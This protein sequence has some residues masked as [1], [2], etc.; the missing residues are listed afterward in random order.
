MSSLTPDQEMSDSLEFSAPSNTQQT[1]DNYAVTTDPTSD[2]SLEAQALDGLEGPSDSDSVASST[3][4]LE[5]SMTGVVTEE[6]ELQQPTYPAHDNDNPDISL[7]SLMPTSRELYSQQL[8]YLPTTD[9]M[10]WH[11]QGFKGLVD[12]QFRLFREDNVGILRDSVRSYLSIPF[13]WKHH[14]SAAFNVHLNVLLDPE[15]SFDPHGGLVFSMRVP[16]PQE[17]LHLTPSERYEWWIKRQ[18]FQHDS[19]VCL[20]NKDKDMMFAAVGHYKDHNLLKN[21]YGSD[22]VRIFFRPFEQSNRFIDWLLANAD[23]RV[24]RNYT[25]LEFPDLKSWSFVP[26]LR[27]LQQMSNMPDTALST[28][29]EPS[30]LTRPIWIRPAHYA[31]GDNFKFRLGKAVAGDGQHELAVSDLFDSTAMPAGSSLDN[32]QTSAYLHAL[33]HRVALIQGPPGTGKSYTAVAIIETLL[34]NL[35]SDVTGPIL[36]VS[37]TN[38]ALDGLL[39]KLQAAGVSNMIRVGSQSKSD[40]LEDINL[41]VLMKYQPQL[42]EDK[43][44][45]KKAGDKFFGRGR[46]IRSSLAK[47][48]KV[49]DDAERMRICSDI[50]L[51]LERWT[52]AQEEYSAIMARHPLNVLKRASVIGVTAG[53]IAVRRELFEKLD[54]KVI[55]FEEAG[56]IPEALAL[57]SITPSM[58][59]CILIG[60]HKQLLPKV[61]RKELERSTNAQFGFD[62]SLLERLIDFGLPFEVLNMQYRMHPEIS[63]LSRCTLYPMLEDAAAVQHLPA[64][65]SL[66]E[67]IFWFDHQQHETKLGKAIKVNTLEAEMITGLVRHLVSQDDVQGGNILV[68]TPYVAQA[69]ALQKKIEEFHPVEVVFGKDSRDQEQPVDV[70]L[71][72][73]RIATV[74]SIQGDESEIVLLSMVRSN[75]WEST[76]FIKSENRAIVALSRAK[77]AM[78]IFGNMTMLQKVPFWSQVLSALDEANKIGTAL[79]V[80]CP[81]HPGHTIQIKEPA[82]FGRYSPNGGCEVPCGKP[83]ACNHRCPELCHGDLLHGRTVCL[84]PCREVLDCGHTCANVCGVACTERCEV[85]IDNPSVVLPCGHKAPSGIPC[86]KYQDPVLLQDACSESVEVQLDCGHKIQR[87]CPEDDVPACASDC[88]KPLPCGHNCV[89]QCHVGHDCPPCQSP[90]A[91][92]CQHQTCRETCSEICIPCLHPDCAASLHAGTRQFVMN[93]RTMYARLANDAL[94]EIRK[95]QAT[96][97]AASG[98]LSKRL[99]KKP[100]TITSDAGGKRTHITAINRLAGGTRYKATLGLLSSLSTLFQRAAAAE[101]ALQHAWDSHPHHPR[102]QLQERILLLLLSARLEVAAVADFLAL[103]A[104]SGAA[105]QPLTLDFAACRA[106]CEKVAEA[107]RARGLPGVAAEADVV[108]AQ[109]GVLE[110]RAPVGHPEALRGEAV[111]RLG[112]AEGALAALAEEGFGARWCEGIR[113]E[114]RNARRALAGEEGRWG[115]DVGVRADGFAARVEAGVREVRGAVVWRVCGRGHYF[116]VGVAEGGGVCSGCGGPAWVRAIAEGEEDV[117]MEGPLES[118]GKSIPFGPLLGATEL[119]H[120]LKFSLDNVLRALLVPTRPSIAFLRPCVAWEIDDTMKICVRAINTSLHARQLACSSHKSSNTMGCYG[121]THGYSRLVLVESTQW[122]RLFKDYGESAWCGSARRF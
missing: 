106:R 77:R 12:R 96:A 67:R 1:G 110:R 104:R 64:V 121:T 9:P 42:P 81:R 18:G 49:N 21:D 105:A 112:G 65:A 74:D 60:D 54:C 122:R 62:K 88:G 109:W 5:E 58:E 85:Q 79:E 15:L 100:A 94:Q 76:G 118:T 68:I 34:Q 33:R 16:Q 75:D 111:G 24:R 70:G 28:A 72:R 89:V 91:L 25:L 95:L 41:D 31:M 32:G 59:H 43:E 71:E 26:P 19:L 40:A 3:H 44:D 119:L 48:T 22:K 116:P 86:Y 101:A 46:G 27:A 120:R 113:V 37:H 56:T 114:V 13:A 17:V 61:N 63:Q 47:L 7:I 4:A 80:D 8:E 39:E 84:E 87:P 36:C 57:T 102:P 78:Y 107:A 117:E 53:G 50:K 73:V 69:K 30:E 115:V 14:S 92:R 29:L 99:S 2:S 90:C 98:D 11:K 10:T 20:W 93:T 82:D 38:R 35:H 83:L 97:L 23:Q 55:V 51:K 6:P 103:R 66:L 52:H 108:W 45:I